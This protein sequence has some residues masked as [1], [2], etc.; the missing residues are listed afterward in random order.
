MAHTG[1]S[2]LTQQDAAYGTDQYADSLATIYS[3]MH[4]FCLSTQLR[5]LRQQAQFMRQRLGALFRIETVA[6]VG[7]LTAKVMRL[8]CGCATGLAARSR[9]ASL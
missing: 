3:E 9:L 8:L 2:V 6:G 4:E 1:Q 5:V 7:L